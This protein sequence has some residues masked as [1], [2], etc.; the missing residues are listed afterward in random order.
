M[1]S[2]NKNL[3]STTSGGQNEI[4]QCLAIINFIQVTR[5]TL[6]F[7]LQSVSYESLKPLKKNLNFI[8][9]QNK[10]NKKDNWTSSIDA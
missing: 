9:T 1:D 6:D 3:A 8:L 5:A 10:I 7:R 4:A 2:N